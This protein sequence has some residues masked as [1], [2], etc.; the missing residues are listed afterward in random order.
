MLYIIKVQSVPQNVIRMSL[1]TC[2][3]KAIN[4]VTLKIYRFL[5]VIRKAR[6]YEN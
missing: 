3:M 2:V 4:D 1:N 6:Y 5:P